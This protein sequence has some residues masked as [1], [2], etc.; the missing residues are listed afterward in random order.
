[1]SG[2]VFVIT[3]FYRRYNKKRTLVNNTSETE[4][5]KNENGIFKIVKKLDAFSPH[6]FWGDG[7]VDP[8]THFIID[9]DF[10]NNKHCCPVNF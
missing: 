6:A 8:K 7:R 2:L 10:I 1:M 9:F 3:E 4:S 5:S